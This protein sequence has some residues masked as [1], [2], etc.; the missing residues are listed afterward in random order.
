MTEWAYRLRLRVEV[1]ILQDVLE[2]CFT[3]PGG[4]SP[5]MSVFPTADVARLRVRTWWVSV[6]SRNWRSA[7]HGAPTAYFLSLAAW[8]MANRSPDW[9]MKKRNRAHKARARLRLRTLWIVAPC[10]PLLRICPA[11][12]QQSGINPAYTPIIDTIFL[13]TTDPNEKLVPR[14]GLEPTH[15]REVADFKSAAS[16]V[17]PPRHVSKAKRATPSQA[18]ALRRFSLASRAV[19][20][21]DV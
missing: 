19:R 17:S 4:I 2:L 5:S 15:L 18:K 21:M 9:S 1:A 12:V 11:F 16:A 8:A 7:Q 13:F 10:C 3:L 6:S 14:E 20:M